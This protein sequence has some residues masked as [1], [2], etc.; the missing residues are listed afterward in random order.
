VLAGAGGT[1]T[2]GASSWH[3]KG[4]VEVPAA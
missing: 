3:P 2:K 1:P 4:E